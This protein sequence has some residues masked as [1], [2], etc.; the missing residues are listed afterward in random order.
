M[1]QGKIVNPYASDDEIPPIKEAEW[2][3]Y[4]RGKFDMVP[5][6]F[7]GNSCFQLYSAGDGGSRIEAVVTY[8]RPETDAE[9]AE[10]ERLEAFRAVRA[11]DKDR[12]EY[13]RLKRIFGDE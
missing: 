10:R 8:Y 1:K 4:I 13:E 9:E 3:A 5:D 2:V 7:R 11:N 12:L 6:E